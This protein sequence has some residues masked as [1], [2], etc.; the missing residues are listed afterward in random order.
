VLLLLLLF[1]DCSAFI[2]IAPL[3]R[4]ETETQAANEQR[5]FNFRFGFGVDRIGS[6]G[7][8]LPEYTSQYTCVFYTVPSAAEKLNQKK[9]S[10]KVLV[11]GIPYLFTIVC[12]C[13]HCYLCFCCSGKGKTIEIGSTRLARHLAVGL[14]EF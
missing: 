11:T 14:G 9:K 2:F 12:L 1:P 3:G 6:V 7:H 4:A 8:S 5:L 10:R 13:F